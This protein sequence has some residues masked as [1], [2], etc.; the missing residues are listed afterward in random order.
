ML[1]LIDHPVCFSR[2]PVLIHRTQEVL[3]WGRAPNPKWRPTGLKATKQSPSVACSPKPSMERRISPL[4]I[5]ATMRRTPTPNRSSGTGCTTLRLCVIPD[6][7]QKGGLLSRLG[8]SR[9]C[10]VGVIF[11]QTSRPWSWIC[12]SREKLWITVTAPSASTSGTTQPA[13]ATFPLG[14]FRQQRPWSFRSTRSNRTSTTITSSSRRLWR[15]RTTSCLTAGWSTRRWRRVPGT[16]CAPTTPHRAAR[17]S[18]PKATC[19][20]CAPNPSKS[21]ASSSPSTALTTS[22][23]RRSARTT[24]TTATPPTSPLGDHMTK[25]EE[26]KRQRAVGPCVVSAYNFRYW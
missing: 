2:R 23:C 11:I 19:P 15:P 25:Q 18:R 3:T 6:P 12:W 13:R 1:Y 26:R 9:R 16:R 22:W 8:S 24:T 7:G 10:S 5:W 20:G 4:W 14:S 21:F 17:R